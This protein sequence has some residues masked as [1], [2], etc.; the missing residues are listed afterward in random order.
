MINMSNFWFLVHLFM[1]YSHGI[2]LIWLWSST[3][4]C[5]GTQNSNKFK[6]HI[7]TCNFRIW[8]I[9]S[10]S[11]I[12]VAHKITHFLSHF[13]AKLTTLKSI[14][15]KKTFVL[16]VKQFIWF[17]S[18]DLSCLLRSLRCNIRYWSSLTS[19]E[20]SRVFFMTT[21]SNKTILTVKI[22]NKKNKSL[23]VILGVQIFFKRD[24]V[25][26]L[27]CMTISTQKVVWP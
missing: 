19:F 22:K 23:E 16:L 20:I 6:F 27:L 5:M 3:F 26:R 1:I 18:L 4:Q 11:M 14:T 13:C 7:A 21:V 8:W 2:N 25:L 17:C 15:I 12:L 9:K 24:L 10:Y